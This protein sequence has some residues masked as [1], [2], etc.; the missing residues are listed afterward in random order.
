MT[1]TSTD[2]KK[3]RLWDGT[4][5]E[6]DE[7]R[8][9]R[10]KPGRQ[11][12][13]DNWLDEVRKYPFPEGEEDLRRG[14]GLLWEPPSEWKD[15]AAYEMLPF[16]VEEAQKEHPELNTDTILQVLYE[17]GHDS[18]K[19]KEQLE[20]I[21]KP[22]EPKTDLLAKTTVAHGKLCTDQGSKQFAEGFQL[23][24]KDLDSIALHTGAPMKQ[25]VA[26]YYNTKFRAPAYD[27]PFLCS[28]SIYNPVESGSVDLK[29]LQNWRPCIGDHDCSKTHSCV[30][31]TSSDGTTTTT[32]TATRQPQPA[33]NAE[34]EADLAIL[35]SA[36]RPTTTT[37]TTVPPF[38]SV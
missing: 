12:P 38:T 10:H 21:P 4:V 33:T 27:Y 9:T 25:V 28:N 3:R 1:D 26:H 11:A 6:D 14:G 8:P 36:S 29:T 16:W 34:V 5:T 20:K 23:F 17:C 30:R 19:A 37:E 31:Y 24:G 18:G 13:P 7:I 2:S 32:T 22:T 15:D 35:R